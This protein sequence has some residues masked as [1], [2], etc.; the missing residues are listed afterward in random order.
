MAILR[1]KMCGGSLE[2][3]E[4][5][6]IVECE[7]CGSVQ[8]LPKLDDAKKVALFDRANYYRSHSEFDK[9]SVVYEN[10]ISEEPDDAEAHWGICLCQY[11]IEYVEDPK[12]KKRIP[13]CHRTQFKS[14]LEDTDY[15]A[16]LD[17]ADVLAKEVYRLE[18]EYIDRVQKSILEISS[19]EEPFDIFICYKETD[20]DGERTTDSVIAQEI[21]TELT[22]EGYKVFFARITLED[23]IGTEYEPYIFAALNSAKVMLVVGTKPEYFNATWV[24]NEWSRYLSFI[25]QGQGKALVPCYRDMDAYDL[26]EEFITFQGQNASKIG[27]KQDLLRGIN[28]LVTPHS[29]Q[30][31]PK[32]DTK[33]NSVNTLLERAFMFLE[34]NEWEK[35]NAYCDKVLDQNPHES[36]AYVC[37]V[38]SKLRL[39]NL[40][41]IDGQFVSLDCN[42]YGRAIKYANEKDRALLEKIKENS[43]KKHVAFSLINCLQALIKNK[44]AVERKELYRQEQYL[45]ATQKMNTAASY[46]DFMLCKANFE[47]L[48][49]FMD[50]ERLAVQCEEKGKL[51]FNTFSEKVNKIRKQLK[52]Y[53]NTITSSNYHVVGLRNDDTVVAVGNNQYGECNVETWKNIKAITSGVFVTIGVKKDGTLVAV[54]I[55]NKNNVDSWKAWKQIKKVV[56]C[57]E[58]IIGLMENGNV[59]STNNGEFCNDFNQW[60]DIIDIKSNDRLVV[61]LKADGTVVASSINREK[62][63]TKQECFD[64]MQWHDVKKIFCFS[65]MTLGIQSDGKVLATIA[66]FREKWWGSRFYK[67]INSLNNIIDVVASVSYTAFLRQ[68]GVAMIYNGSLDLVD[69]WNNIGKIYA[70]FCVI[71]IK[72]D[73]TIVSNEEFENIGDCRDIVNVCF[74]GVLE[75]VVICM[76]IRGKIYFL[77][78]EISSQ[79]KREQEQMKEIKKI[80]DVK[81]LYADDE[82]AEIQKKREQ[83]RIRKNAQIFRSKNLCQYCGGTFKG[84]FFKKCSICGKERDY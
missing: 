20:K 2:V 65:G 82:L 59:I 47:E 45:S 23:K 43:Q 79:G 74:Y 29:T 30:V 15:L 34:D 22:K 35:A 77:N 3:I 36:Q 57:H 32:A 56:Y 83:E 50:S 7:Y 37:K 39:T 72:F 66:E 27:W 38:L 33:E 49:N 80:Q 9:A 21:Y 62:E 31:R 78:G 16:A 28:K 61:G 11:G 46:D 17:N 48:N 58:I 51:A 4:N 67:I 18:A 1:C 84:V 40:E 14:I 69:S 19:K 6:T 25:E 13:T 26:P 12:T 73:G 75:D 55:C 60:H 8:T 24:K 68:D 44:E 71:G 70:G 42:D 76:N 63:K 41:E 53:S 52:R 64:I 81:L 5:S 10:I 54:G